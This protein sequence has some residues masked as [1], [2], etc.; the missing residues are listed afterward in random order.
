MAKC[1]RAFQNLNMKADFKPRYERMFLYESIFN[2]FPDISRLESMD[3]DTRVFKLPAIYRE[4]TD[5]MFKKHNWHYS[6]LSGPE[7]IK[8]I[9]SRYES[10]LSG[11]GGEDASIFIG[12]GVSS[13]LGPVIESILSLNPGKNEVIL[14]SP[15][16]SL[17]HSVVEYA[18]AS[19]VMVYG[20][21][22]NDFIPTIESIK[23]AST[24]KTAAIIFSNPANPSAKAYKREW[25][26][27][28]VDLAEENN[29]F[30]VS[31]EI[32]SE[33]LDSP[34]EYVSIANLKGSY[35]N[36]V[37]LFGLSKDRPGITGMRSGYSI[38]DKRLDSMMSRI[39]MTRNFSTNMLADHILAADIA[40]RELAL[41]G[42][43]SVLLDQYSDKAIQTYIRTIALNLKK[44]RIFRKKTLTE[45]RNNKHIIDIVEPDGGNCIFFRY[46]K[47][48]G[49][50]ELAHEFG[51]KGLAIYPCD[52][53]NMD[54]LQQGS[55]TRVCITQSFDFL[56]ENIKK[57]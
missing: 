53:F 39:Q 55:W 51:R 12:S 36:F 15:D 54:P 9:I 40:L 37:R 24:S 8:H 6:E 5:E 34:N 43:R 2:L 38:G 57:I 35:K 29:I 45:M 4:V 3:Y 17:F 18:D 44:L 52:A 21:R 23:Q 19:P 32:Y 1:Q 26:K 56:R 20:E 25:L 33:M 42:Y 11:L 46:Y 10:S 13:L 14:F 47:D 48:M 16:Y 49:A 7:G 27:A 31:D 50:Q 28:L 22:K 30:I 41:T